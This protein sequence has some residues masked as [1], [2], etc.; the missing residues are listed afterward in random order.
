MQWYA[1]FVE[2]RREDRLKKCIERTCPEDSIKALVP[3]RKLIERRQ[4]KEY[5]R[6]LTLFPGYVFVRACMDGFDVYYKLSKLPGVI[7]ILKDGVYPVDVPEEEMNI[8][9][10]LTRFG[11]VIDFSNLYREGDKIKVSSG[12]LEGLEG[13]IYKYDHR[14]KRAK[15]IINLLDTEKRVD[16]GANMITREV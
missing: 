12:P 16:L 2:A 10:S 3:K 7:S 4:G 14:K 5:E 6:I 13:I 15:V 11:E 9:L 8:I 1:I